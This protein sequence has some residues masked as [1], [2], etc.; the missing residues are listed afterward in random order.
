M[1]GHGKAVLS[2][3]FGG[4][5]G[6]GEV[7]IAG[8]RS[9]IRNV[10]PAVAHDWLVMAHGIQC[11]LSVP[12][13]ATVVLE[14]FQITTIIRTLTE[15]AMTAQ[16]VLKIGIHLNLLGEL[17]SLDFDEGGADGLHVRVVVVKNDAT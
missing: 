9:A 8:G 4:S 13:G 17:W 7:I 3:F 2:D 5:I 11:V 1:D 10:A 16:R 14:T 6:A 12:A 15:V